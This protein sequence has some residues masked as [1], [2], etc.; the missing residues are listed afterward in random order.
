MEDVLRIRF[1]GSS[2]TLFSRVITGF[3]AELEVDLPTGDRNLAFALQMRPLRI[4]TWSR[5]S[6]MCRSG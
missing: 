5:S 4:G 3:V 6:K 1:D 2:E